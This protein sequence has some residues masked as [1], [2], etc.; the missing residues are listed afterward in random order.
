MHK[1]N[2]G[3]V[4]SDE[5]YSKLYKPGLYIVVCSIVGLILMRSTYNAI[6]LFTTATLYRSHMYTVE[7]WHCWGH[8]QALRKKL[9]ALQA[10]RRIQVTG[11]IER[12]LRSDIQ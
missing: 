9:G 4:I 10:T 3:E 12:L 5:S 2:L 7:R 1:R 8:D 6:M 11:Q